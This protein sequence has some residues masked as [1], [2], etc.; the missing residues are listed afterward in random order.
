M[1]SHG[2]H[3]WSRVANGGQS[4]SA[5][6]VTSGQEWLMVASHGQPW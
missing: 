5:M 4:W 1:V 3:E 6:V 2:S